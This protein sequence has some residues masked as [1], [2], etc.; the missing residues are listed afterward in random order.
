MALTQVTGPYPIFTDLDG[1]PLDDGYLY[2]GEINEDPEQN[3]IQVFFD[4][5]LT[6]PATQPIRT[7][8]GYAYRNGTPALLYT[9]GEFSIT[10][11]NKRQEFV[12][13]SPVGYGFDPAAVSASVVKNDFVGN[14]VQVAFVLSASPSTILAT[15]IFINGVYQEKDSYTLSGNTITFSIAP[16]LNSSIEVMTNETG[17]I[18]TG[19]ATAITYTLTASNAVQQTVQTKLEQYISIKD[20]GAVGDGVTDD[21]AA[22]QALADYVSSTEGAYVI[23]PEGTY[24]V[25]R[26]GAPETVNFEFVDCKS[27]TWEFVGG[28][29]ISFKADF[30]HSISLVSSKIVFRNCQNLVLVNI[31]TDGNV[32]TGTKVGVEQ[33]EHGLNFFGCQGVQLLNAKLHDHPNDGL[34]IDHTFS[35]GAI[36][37]PSERFYVSNLDTYNNGRQGMSL[38]GVFGAIF[39]N[40]TFRDTGNTGGFGSYSPG[41]GVDIEPNTTT[42]IC[43]RNVIFNNPMIYGNIGPIFVCVNLASPT[44]PGVAITGNVDDIHINNPNFKASST[45]TGSDQLIFAVKNGFINGGQTVLTDGNTT[46]PRITPMYADFLSSVKIKDHKVYGKNQSLLAIKDATR[47][48]LD[49]SVVIEGCS[50]IC[51]N[52]VSNGG[53]IFLQIDA[54][55]Q[56]NDNYVYLPSAAYS[57]GSATREVVRLRKLNIASGNIYD[58]NMSTVSQQFIT[59]Y[60]DAVTVANETYKSP[61][62]F[63]ALNDVGAPQ[64]A[65]YG[66]G[67]FS[68]GM[69]LNLYD[70]RGTAS[71]NAVSRVFSSLSVPSSGTWQRGDIVFNSQPS[72]GG[73]IGW[74]CTSSGTPGTWKT[75]GSITV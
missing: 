68:P 67:Q 75:F 72:A 23:W 30:V 52:T 59:D 64:V 9:G 24:Y 50:F 45:S 42:E 43:V 37:V 71:G 17:V 44:Y 56:F 51:E 74:A 2:I 66:R 28:A 27:M 48:T 54:G 73:F 55:G 10:I 1:T 11:R 58:T 26:T 13:Y 33:G 57:T 41:A 70:F 22:I 6:I 65:M 32:S 47:S 20:F 46:N 25:A 38:I 40:C 5:N 8:N 18:N 7:N 69:Q 39:D 4:A 35:G 34:Y 63:W 49:Q 29:K 3:P 62:Y 60:A 36:S 61:T 14:G 16:P 19:N 15:N 21:T 53:A 12:L 31:E